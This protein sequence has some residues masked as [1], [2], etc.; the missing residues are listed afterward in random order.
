MMVEVDSWN[1]S[2]SEVTY[3]VGRIRGGSAL[4]MVPDLAVGR[5][6]IR[7]KSLE[8]KDEAIARMKNLVAAHSEQDGITTRMHGDFK[9]P[10][11]PMNDGIE[12]MQRRIEACGR[13]LDMEIKWRG[14]GGACDGNRFADAGLPNIDT[15]GPSGDFIH[16]DRE[17]LMPES[18]VPRAKLASLVLMSFTHE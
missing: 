9:S 12:S 2:E 6:N 7:V 10:P 17:F 11:K 5:I 15:L 14:T 16:S 18:L 13:K 3:N 4:N 8:Q 1:D